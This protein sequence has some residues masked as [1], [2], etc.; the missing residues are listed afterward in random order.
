MPIYTIEFTR[1][2]IEKVA[3]RNQDEA[4][5]QAYQDEV[6]YDWLSFEAQAKVIEIDGKDA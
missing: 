4:L 1:T 5:D 6:N 2:I 3:A